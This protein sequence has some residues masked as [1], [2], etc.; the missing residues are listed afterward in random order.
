M[1]TF[2]GHNPWFVHI[3]ILFRLLPVL[4]KHIYIILYRYVS[5]TFQHTQQE[6]FS[7]KNYIQKISTYESEF[8]DSV[9]L[10]SLRCDFH[11]LYL[12]MRST[13][14]EFFFA[15]RMNGN[16]SS[17]LAV[18]LCNTTYNKYKMFVFRKCLLTDTAMTIH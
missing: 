10:S 7:R 1:W 2:N 18:G 14:Y 3:T 16:L 12:S 17:S 13:R 11:F 5:Y 6:K 8:S 4:H 15:L 9:S